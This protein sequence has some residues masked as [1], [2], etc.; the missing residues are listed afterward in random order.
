MSL[1]YQGQQLQLAR[2]RIRLSM[3]SLKTLGEYWP[4][5]KRMYQEVGVIAREFLSLGAGHE[6]SFVHELSRYQPMAT[7]ELPQPYS[8]QPNS[9]VD[10]CELYN[11]LFDRAIDSI[12]PVSV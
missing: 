5:E 9:S 6:T 10:F 11:I 12:Q 3:G 4:T 7:V 8:F 2:E 1:L